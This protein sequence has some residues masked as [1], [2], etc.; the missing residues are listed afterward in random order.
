M[1]YSTKNKKNTITKKKI[2][3]MGNAN[4]EFYA[5]SKKQ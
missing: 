3:A 4:Q 2:M 5:K 1:Q